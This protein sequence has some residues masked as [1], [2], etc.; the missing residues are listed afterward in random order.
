MARLEQEEEENEEE[1]EAI[2]GLFL[3]IGNR[4]SFQASVLTKN[5]R[6]PNTTA[7]SV[8]GGSAQASALTRP[9]PAILSTPEPQ[10]DETKQITAERASTSTPSCRSSPAF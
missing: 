3:W 10:C 6:T 5:G 8:L 9:Q 7:A 4:A 2:H 1:G